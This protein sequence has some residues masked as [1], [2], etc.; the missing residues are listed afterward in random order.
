[1]RR[2]IKGKLTTSV[3]VIVVAIIVLTT[4]G[5]ILIAGNQM[6]DKSENELQLQADKYANAI[7]TWMENEMMMA[8]GTANS[9]EVTGELSGGFLQKV[10]DT[11]AEGREELLNLYCGTADS[12]FYQS[13]YEAVIPEG[14][15]PVAR[16]WYQQA[17]QAGKTIVTDPYWDVLT[18]QM[19]ATIASPIYVDDELAAVIGADVTLTTVT[20][21]TSSID[22]EK[23]V[24]GFLVDS[25]NNYVSHK[26]DDYE[27]TE[28]AATAVKDIMPKLESLVADAGNKVLRTKDYDGTNCYFAASVV[29]SCN[30]KLGV[31][32]PSANVRKALNAMVLLAVIITVIAIV[33]VVVIMAGLIGK[34]LEPIQTLKQFA[35]GDFSE[36]A[37]VQKTIPSQFKDETEQITV[38]TA[39]VKDQIRGI[40]LNTK[41]EADRIGR[42]TE[43]A[44]GEMTELHTNISEITNA[45][46]E[47]SGQTEEASELVSGINEAG[48]ELGN[49]ID[50]VANKAGEVAQQSGGIMERA[51]TLYNSSLESSNQANELYNETKGELERAIESSKHVDEINTLAEEILT[52]SDQTNMIA[53]NA[54][55]EAARAGEAGKGFAVV[56]EEIRVLADNSRDAV[57]KIKHVTDGIVQSV[58]N[59]ANHSQ[60]LLQFMNDKVVADYEHMIN[61]ASQYEQDAIYYNAVASELGASSQEMSANMDNIKETIA[62]IVALTGSMEEC[63]EN[64]GSSAKNSDDSSDIILKKVKE[65]SEL[66]DALNETVKAFKV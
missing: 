28:D 42:I 30:W 65:L 54:S 5:V 18:N 52:I 24:Y 21:L 47:V 59:L 32:V 55:I 12:R 38:A 33:L 13:N 51:R 40:I 58:T 41:D 36:N 56:A 64:I 46:E 35:S 9:V 29:E 10:V 53:L 50:M 2:T 8:E 25:S 48:L 1:M 49:A 17:A 11:H 57:D 20:D 34:L 45:V 61:I 4:L 44:F 27:P 66:S 63:M 60:T 19:C 14:Y 26:N 7:N 31:S 3:I 6:T 16:G 37:T 62:S 22:Y 23:G 15:D 43:D 39:N